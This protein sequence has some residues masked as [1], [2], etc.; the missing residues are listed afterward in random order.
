M[1]Q[2]IFSRVLINF[3]LTDINQSTA[4]SFLTYL[5]IVDHVEGKIKGMSRLN[6]EISMFFGD[7]TLW[8]ICQNPVGRQYCEKQ[9]FML[10]EIYKY[11]QTSFFDP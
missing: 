10:I 6:V 8:D 9:Y 2:K 11:N 5:G 1:Y 3:K 7:P 4:E